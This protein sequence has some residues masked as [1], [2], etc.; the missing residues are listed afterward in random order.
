MPHLFFKKNPKKYLYV[1]DITLYIRFKK[2]VSPYKVH[3]GEIQETPKTEVSESLSDNSL[4]SLFLIF[5]SKCWN[6]FVE[7]HF[8]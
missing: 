1:V 3:S 6:L 8:S 2:E 7:E 4:N 5:F